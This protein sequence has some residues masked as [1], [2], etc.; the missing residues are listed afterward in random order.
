MNSF[1]VLTNEFQGSNHV[2]TVYC[3]GRK[4]GTHKGGFSTFRCD[5]TP[6]MKA[7]GNVLTVV[8]TNAASDISPQTADFTFLFRISITSADRPPL[9]RR[10]IWGER[11]LPGHKKLLHIHTFQRQKLYLLVNSPGIASQV[12]VCAHHPMAGNDNRNGVMSH[13][14]AHRL[15]RHGL[16]AKICRYPFGNSAVGRHL[17]IWDPAKTFPHRLPKRAANRPQRQ[18]PGTGLLSG[19]ITVKPITHFTKYFQI[20]PGARHFRKRVQK[21]FLPVQP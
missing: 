10:C 7:S 20:I 6:A 15:R 3:S 8:V 13:S 14:A 21:I 11:A 4:P 12:S 17:P 16:F 1:V 9:G 2:A 19:E 18:L 5:L